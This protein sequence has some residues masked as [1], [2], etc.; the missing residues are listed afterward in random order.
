MKLYV[1]AKELLS[2]YN[3]LYERF[4]VGYN[5]LYEVDDPRRATNASLFELYKRVRAC[6]LASIGNKLVDQ[7]DNWIE[8]QQRRITELGDV[9]LE[10][11]TLQELPGEIA[12]DLAQGQEHVIMTAEDLDVLPDTYPRKGPPSPHMPRPGKFRSHRR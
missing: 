5:V 11:T 8:G 10:G 9:K 6:V 3:V 2:L 7:L 1:N 4:E 12:S